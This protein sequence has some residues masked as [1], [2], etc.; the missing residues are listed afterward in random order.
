LLTLVLALGLG[1]RAAWAQAPGPAPTAPPAAAEPTLT[2]IRPAA[3]AAPAAAPIAAPAPA[4]APAGPKVDPWYEVLAK[5]PY[6]TETSIWMPEAVNAAGH[7]AD[8][9]FFWVMVLS[10]VCFVGITGV[11]VYFVIRY[12]HRPG[13]KAE[14]SPSHNDNMEIT[15]TVIP[16]IIVCFLFFFGWRGYIELVSTPAKAVEIRVDARA[17]SWQFSH[18]NGYSDN[19]LHVPVNTPVRLV[20]K[21]D[22]FLHSFF[23]PAF[24][25]KQDVLP[26]RY[27]HVWFQATKPGVYRLY[28]TEYCGT[29]HSLMKS[30]VVVH[31]PGKY[32]KY[33]EETAAAGADGS[34][35]FE[36]KGCVACHSTDGSAKIGPSFKGIFGASATLVDGSTVTVDETYLRRSI[37]NPQAQARPGFPPTMPPFEGQ[38]KEAEIEALIQFIKDKK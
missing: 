20:M 1:A 24:R 12:R 25:V 8:Q 28:C 33:L 15:W 34:V 37:L 14:P 30:V 29:N 11:V 22:D 16:T 3:E 23:V 36:K 5:T 7:G 13:H 26:N 27:T 18:A 31:D 32:E 19:N 6:S 21:S 17:W 38:L 9:M 35:L 2:P 4:A 10:V